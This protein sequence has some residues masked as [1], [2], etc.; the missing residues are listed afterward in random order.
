V[1]VG[2]MRWVGVVMALAVAGLAA[3][4]HAD[5]I[6]QW[7][8]GDLVHYSNTPSSGEPWKKV[9]DAGGV[10][11]AE[12]TVPGG[13]PAA[14]AEADSLSAQ[15]SL[16]RNALERDLRATRR[17]I[18]ELDARLAALGRARG[19]NA[20]GSDATGGVGAQALDF[21]SEEEKALAADREGLAKHVDEVH[22]EA[23]KIREELSARLGGVPAWWNDPH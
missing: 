19:Q 18:Q 17:R 14:D 22:D 1:E 3:P 20:K 21:R 6:Y 15:A 10:P 8:D 9:P 13:A 11:D 5:D 2:I 16:R 7:T 23:A 12:A 4:A